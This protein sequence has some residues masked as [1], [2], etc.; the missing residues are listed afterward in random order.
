[1]CFRERILQIKCLRRPL[2]IWLC[3]GAHLVCT[4]SALIVF[5]RLSLDKSL[6]DIFKNT[7]PPFPTVKCRSLVF[8]LEHTIPT[9]QCCS[10]Y[11]LS[12]GRLRFFLY[13]HHRNN[14]DNL[15][16]KFV[17]F[18]GHQMFLLFSCSILLLV[19]N[20]SLHLFQVDV[21]VSWMLNALLL[22][23]SLHYLQRSPSLD[24]CF[25]AKQEKSNKT[26][27]CHRREKLKFLNCNGLRYF[28]EED[29]D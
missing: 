12:L 1:M 21:L 27:L 17:K 4:M 10:L 18:Q 3:L 2:F 14:E 9:L 8:D 11:L 16:G 7:I 20:L 25:R 5:T 24:G 28:L 13:W 29:F 15:S 6:E 26:Y 19:L 23:K 22:W